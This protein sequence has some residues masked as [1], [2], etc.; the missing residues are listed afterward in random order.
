[1]IKPKDVILHAG[2]FLPNAFGKAEI[3]AVAVVVVLW[4]NA[5]DLTEWT[6]VSRRQIVNFLHEEALRQR[7]PVFS[8]V[9]N[10][11]LRPDPNGLRDGGWFSGWTTA[12]EPGTFTEEGLRRL[13]HATSE[14]A[15]LSS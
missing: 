13:S 5:N 7:E 4:H 1:M 3:E 11:F 12:E 14:A 6:P 2:C 9:S 8:M 15:R 10:P